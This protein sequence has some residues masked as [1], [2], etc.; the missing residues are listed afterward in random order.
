[1]KR[2]ILPA[3]LLLIVSLS[4]CRKDIIDYYPGNKTS[5][6]SNSIKVNEEDLLRKIT[7]N[8]S[9][10]NV[11]TSISGTV[12][13]LVYTRDINVLLDPKG[14]DLSYSVRLNEDF[15][16]SALGRLSYTLPAPNSS[17]TTDWAGND[18]KVLTEVTK[19]EVNIN[20]KSMVN[21][22]LLR[23]FTF[24]KNC[25][26]VQEA[27]TQQNTLLNTKTDLVKFTSYVAFDKEYPAST[28]SSVLV[29]TK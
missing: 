4:S 26:T 1:M 8:T 9:A 10:Q 18:L 25:V 3:T 13:K 24:V 21:L 16:A 19:T 23:Y 28:V 22:H 5:I 7:F 27:V 11:K 2:T 6:N 17:Y 20:G 15:S 29:Y 14:Y 12:L